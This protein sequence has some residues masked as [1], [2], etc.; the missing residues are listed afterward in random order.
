MTGSPFLTARWSNLVLL[1]FEVPEELLR[2]RIHQSLEL[3]RWNG[4]THASLVAFDFLDTRV[5]GCRIPGLADFPE[6]NL[7]TYVRHREQRGVTFIRELVPSRMIAAVARSLYNE[8]YLAADLKS[9]IVPDGPDLIADRRWTLGGQRHRLTVRASADGSVPS[10]SGPEH[11]FKEH[12]WGFG[13]SRTGQLLTYRVD[14]PVWAVRQVKSVDCQVDF[15]A[16]YG[17]EWSLLTH[18]EP[19]SVIFATGSEVAVYPPQVEVTHGE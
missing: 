3:D 2:G 13:S 19:V 12:T 1:T 8:P 17:A 14:H 5:W 11:H 7:R 15:G 16:L 18:R 4:Q 10:P 9:R 6:V